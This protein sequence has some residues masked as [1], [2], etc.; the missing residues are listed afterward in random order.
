MSTKAYILSDTDF[1][2]LTA[3]IDRD[4]RWGLHGG[5]STVFNHAERDANDVAHRFFNYQVTTWIERMKRG[6]A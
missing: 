3:A 6:G 5:S 4:P 2:E 1:A